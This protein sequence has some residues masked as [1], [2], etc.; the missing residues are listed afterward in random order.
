MSNPSVAGRELRW[1][2]EACYWGPNLWSMEPVVVRRLAMTAEQALQLQEGASRLRVHYPDW[3][4][5]SP[6][7][8]REPRIT[9]ADTVAKVVASWALGALNEVR[10][11]LHDAGAA[12][13]VEGLTIWV[14]FHHPDVTGLAMDLALVALKTAGDRTD[15]SADLMKSGLERLWQFCRRSHPDY[16]ARILMAA[17]RQRN[18]PV[19]Q[20]LPVTKYWQYGWGAQSRVFLESSSNADGL[21]GAGLATRKPLAKA[22]FA[23]LGMPTPRHCIVNDAAQLE[24]AS[25][26][27]RFPCVLKPVDMN[28]GKGVT[29]NIHTLSQLRAAFEYARGVTDGSVMVEQFVAGDDHRLMVV[30]G[31]LVAAVRRQASTVVGDGTSTA[32]QLIARLNADRSDNL[33]K[34]RYL[35]PIAIDDLL[36]SHLA[37]QQVGLD[38]VL[39]AGDC[40]TLRSNSNV[41][42]G[43][44]VLDVTERV[45]P[46]VVAMAQQLAVTVGLETAGLDYLT[47]DIA[48]PCSEGDGAF[49][50]MNSTPGI[51][52]PITAGWSADT[53]G[54]IVLGEVP[55]RIPVDVCVLHALDLQ[56]ARRV[57]PSDATKG[58]ACV[59]GS[60]V[61]ADG[62]A[63]H[64]ADTTPWAA[65][66]AALRNRT[67]TSLQI[68]CTPSEV[69]AHG[70]PLD[71]V[72]RVWL[73]GASFPEPWNAVLRRWAGSVE[74]VERQSMGSPGG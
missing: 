65:V 51:D 2:D 44:V 17:A 30:R 66:R 14:G 24:L 25:T 67:V 57:L 42:T 36:V 10:G 45:H 22:V 9:P 43:G 27:I 73:V 3:I 61:Y 56:A 15:F 62:V 48:R 11:Y 21:V 28:G 71:R 46:Q 33:I 34:S 39:P 69:M 63:L 64:I 12:E 59:C 13:T 72:D 58:R 6:W 4:D 32:R 68:A 8:E 7:H 54:A 47:T 37:L 74:V 52:L 16:Q 19:L 18:I 38:S 55:G 40:I 53:I 60:D 35:V 26:Q 1:S 5:D 29:A 31:K 41:S 70:F 20:F 23:S 49:I 50:E